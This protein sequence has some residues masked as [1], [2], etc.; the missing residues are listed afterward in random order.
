MDLKRIAYRCSM[1]SGALLLAGAVAFAQQQMPQQQAPS[2][3][4]QSQQPS[5]TNPN[6]GNPGNNQGAPT[7]QDFGEKMFVS[8]AMEDGQAE[9]QLSQLAQQKSQSNDVKQL[10]QKLMTDHMQ[11]EEKWFKPMSQQLGVT[12]P[13][14]PSKKDKKIAEKLQNASGADFD[15]QYLTIVAKEHQKDLKEF[16]D[17]ATAAQDPSVKQ[18][19]ERGADVIAK[20][21]QLIEQVA[22]SHNVTLD[23]KS[24]QSGSM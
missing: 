24:K 11:M 16:K 5:T 18:V 21:L 10:A 23:E 3:M 4:P 17:E 9:M 8:K 7:S 1:G 12:E 2:G 13:K 15:T 19:A 14:G 22:K 20:H 6:M